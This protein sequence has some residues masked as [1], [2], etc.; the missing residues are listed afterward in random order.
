MIRE[1]IAKLVEGEDLTADETVAA[2]DAIMS[3]RATDAQIAAF[4][5][6]LRLKGETIEE[7][8]GCAR[9]MRQKARRIQAPFPDV[10]DTCGTGGD[11]SGTLN[12]STAA[13]LV[14]AGA[15]CRVAKHGN[16][17]VSSASGSADV[18]AELGANIAVE[19]DVVERCL[20]EA[21]IGFLFAPSLHQAMK[22]A[23]GPRRE[24]GIRTIFNILG[25]LTNPAFASRQLLGVYDAALLEPMA[26][27]LARLGSVRCLVVHG[28]DG[29]D[30]LT[31]TAASQVCQLDAGRV[32]SYRV[33]PQDLGLPRADL[34][35]LRVASPAESAAAIR[36]VLAGRPGPHRDIVALNAGAALV[37]AGKATDLP[38][39]LRLAGESLD[40]GA[41][42]RVLDRLIRITNA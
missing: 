15:G 8:A 18:L 30:E 27:V 28:E 32:R 33:E 4:V 12:V 9:V 34:D 21:G 7:I 6:A 37:A 19:P 23:I 22:Y 41:A 5:V 1:A 17:S 29:L 14:A 35:D 11:A 2:M 24:M 31:T 25:P 42:S 13:A 39:G 10:L 36:G 20:A 40:S 26:H 16:R 38:E 3:G